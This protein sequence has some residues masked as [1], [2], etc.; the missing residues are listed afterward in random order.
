MDDKRGRYHHGDLREALICGTKDLVIERGAENFTLADACRAA[1]VST[2]AP[3]K[4]FASRDDIL[5]EVVARALVQLTEKALEAGR[6]A[7]EGSAQALI[8]MSQA[9]LRFARENPAIFR[10]MFGQQPELKKSPVVLKQAH[11]SFEVA[12]AHVAAYCKREGIDV[13]PRQL[14]LRLWSFA[15]GVASLV[16]DGDYDIIAPG[17]DVEQLLAETMMELLQVRD[18]PASG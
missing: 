11:A 4:H 3:Y 5:A 16:I 17:L 7:G 10:L 13:D 14:H 9:Y 1:G 12:L 15:H 8:A 6:A 18:R 2:A